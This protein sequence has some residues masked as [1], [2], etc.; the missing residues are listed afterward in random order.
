[1]PSKVL[2]FFHLRQHSEFFSHYQI[3][4]TS[5]ILLTCQVSANHQNKLWAKFYF[6]GKKKYFPPRFVT[7]TC[8]KIKNYI[9]NRFRQIKSFSGLQ[10]DKL[11]VLCKSNRLVSFGTLEL[12]SK[13]IHM[14]HWKF[15]SDYGS[16]CGSR[17]YSQLDSSLVFILVVE[18]SSEGSYWNHYN[19]LF[20]Y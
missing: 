2:A 4:Q 10:C 8:V 7:Q 5:I 18:L 19:I 11:I 12:Q 9:F 3:I 20:C 6:F 15:W 17:F 14:H 1:M 13:T 16:D